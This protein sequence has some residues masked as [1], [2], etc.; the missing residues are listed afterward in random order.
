VQAADFSTDYKVEYSIDTQGT[1]TIKQDITLTNHTQDRYVSDYTLT[2][3]SPNISSVRAWDQSGNLTT[4]LEQQKESSTIKVLL[5]Q[6][7]AGKN[8][9]TSWTLEYK[10]SGFAEKKGR[11]WEIRIPRVENASPVT[12]YSLDLQIPSVFGTPQLQIPSATSEKEKGD[13]YQLIF[14][15]SQGIRVRD[16]GLLVVFGDYQLFSFELIYQLNN[17]LNVKAGTEIALLP[18]ITGL[19]EVFIKELN[20]RPEEI[21]Q[22]ADGNYL[23]SYFLNPKEELEI[24]FSG[25]VEVRLPEPG[26]NQDRYDY[27][28]ER[29]H[30]LYTM[31]TKYWEANN[32]KI[33]D[34]VENQ[35]NAADK[36][37]EKAS[38]LYRYT[39][40]HLEYNTARF[41]NEVTRLGALAALEQSNN[42][43]CME[44]TDLLVTL[45]RTAGIPAREIDGYAYAPETEE[46]IPQ[47]DVLHSWVQFYDDQTRTWIYV[48]PTWEDTSGRDYFNHLDTDRIIFV[49]KGIDSEQ[50]YPAGSYKSD[51]G[52]SQDQSQVKVS[53]ADTR[54]SNT[55][56]FS[57]WL[58][59]WE[60][61]R[62]HDNLLDSLFKI[63]LRILEQIKQLA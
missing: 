46:K 4:L 60:E 35:T 47:Q 14:S 34:I 8:T 12:S 52:S 10:S 38:K 37:L 33:V 11:I 30:A 54:E 55:L 21:K 45:L 57:L 5:G 43:V 49:I 1:A 63:I 13:Y 16:N 59:N 51:N 36:T 26:N 53:F 56:P 22:D 27:S 32:Q 31:P 58:Q 42:A 15:D 62:Q 23:A 2:D 7:T 18:N 25:Q 6:K 61:D 3:Y 19:Q 17:P 9:K 20:P 29:S 24:N 40:N 39:L 41:E 44:Y 50:P 48:D 28:T